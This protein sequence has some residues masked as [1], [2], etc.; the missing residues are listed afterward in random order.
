MQRSSVWIVCC[1]KTFS[2]IGWI[3]GANSALNVRVVL[4]FIILVLYLL[5]GVKWY[6]N[7]LSLFNFNQGFFVIYWVS[8]CYRLKCMLHL[9]VFVIITDVRI[10]YSCCFIS[11]D[12]N[13]YKLLCVLVFFIINKPVIF[14]GQKGNPCTHANIQITSFK[15]IFAWDFNNL[16]IWR[17]NILDDINTNLLITHELVCFFNCIME[18]KTNQIKITIMMYFPKKAFY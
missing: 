17:M 5:N 10:L 1:G 13:Y 11:W 12:K 8:F 18:S 7:R 2:N 4:L 3:L 15:L 16:F 14:A 9:T 6:E